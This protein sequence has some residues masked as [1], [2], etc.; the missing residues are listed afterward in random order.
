MVVESLV[1]AHQLSIENL[2]E[3]EDEDEGGKQVEEFE[4]M[5]RHDAKDAED[6]ESPKIPAAFKAASLGGSGQEPEQ[7]VSVWLSEVASQHSSSRPATPVSVASEVQQQPFVLTGKWTTERQDNFR[8]PGITGRNSTHL[9]NPKEIM[10]E[11]R[12]RENLA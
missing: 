7:K 8:Q 6:P 12:R 11:R 1:I 10:Q 9:C 5:E 2:Q 4:M 3:L